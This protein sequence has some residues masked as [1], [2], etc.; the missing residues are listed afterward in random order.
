MKH[1]IFDLGN[2][3]FRFDL[4]HILAYRFAPEVASEI[5]PIFFDRRIWDR[6]DD[7][8]ISDRDAKDAICALLPPEYHQGAREVYD[9]WPDLL[10][11]V[12][13]MPE[14]VRELKEQGHKLYLLSNISIGFVEQSMKNPMYREVFDLFDGLVFSGPIGITKPKPEIF[15]YLL[16]TYHLRAQDCIFIDD[17][18]VNTEG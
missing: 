10:Y 11:P 15:E 2:V 1:C 14:L 18:P 12:A 3:L 9:A 5:A 6:M 4:E 8:T 13:G 7:G 17:S 16:S